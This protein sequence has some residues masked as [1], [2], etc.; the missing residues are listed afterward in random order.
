MGPL[1]HSHERHRTH[2][3]S[4]GLRLAGLVR[5]P[6]WSWMIKRHF[7]PL[8]GHA[9]R[10]GAAQKSANGADMNL[11]QTFLWATLARRNPTKL[12]RA[13]RVQ[14]GRG[15][16]CVFTSEL[17]PAAGAS[18][19]AACTQRWAQSDVLHSWKH[20]DLP[21]T[22]ALLVRSALLSCC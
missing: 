21:L 4:C 16:C 19:S 9:R 17:C 8:R 15:P 18:S 7:N 20:R 12:H 5:M 13:F 3:T 10:V 22:L 14:V 6:S 11:K 2:F 1:C